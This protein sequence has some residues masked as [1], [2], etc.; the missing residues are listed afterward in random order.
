MSG[1]VRAELGPPSRSALPRDALIQNGIAAITVLL[2]ATPL[3]PILY[4]SFVDRALYDA[5]QRFTLQNYVHLL[6]SPT[7]HEAVANTLLFAVLGTI[8]AQALGLATAI[9]VGRTD[10]PGRRIFGETLVWPLYLS[11][12]V[13]AFGWTIMYG[14][15][16]YVTGLA[17]LL[18]GVQQ[19]WDLYTI[20]G[21]AVVAGVAS[22]PLTFLYCISSVTAQDP[23][24]EAAARSVGAS[25]VRALL[26][27]SLPLLRPALVFSTVQNFVVI[28]ETLSIPLLLGNPVG[29]R[30]FTTYLY[31]EGLD[32]A[33]PD[34]GL[35]GAAAVVL[36]LVVTL[37]IVLQNR[38]LRNAQ[39]FV[40]VGGKASRP[41]P[42]ELGAWRW[43]AFA[44]LLF[45]LVFGV[46]AVLAGLFLRTATS[47]LTP[48][49]PPWEMLTWDNVALI[50]SYDAYVRSI[51]N[52]LIIATV[53]GAIGTLLIAMIALVAHRSDYRFRRAMETIALYP[54]AVPGLLIGLGAFYALM[55]F[56]ALGWLR[57]TIAILVV[58]FI[59]RYI[60]TG[61]GAVAPILLQ[62]GRDLDRGARSVG[63]DWWTT[64]TRILMGLIKSAMLACFA[65]LFI[66]F[67]KEYTAAVFL[68]APGSEVMGTTMLTFWVQGDAG[69]VAALACLQVVITALFLVLARRV[70]GV[71]IYG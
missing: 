39:R 52:T 16:G 15:S 33:R 9:L 2:V 62:I 38:L 66:H 67:V 64:C 48:F 49:V 40:T 36:V 65:L 35:V 22:A 32:A 51:W 37:L 6:A 8:I 29:L 1:L 47:F 42:L 10:V 17:S 18:T 7:F 70:F 63:A 28:V 46:L 59:M 57:N 34:Y 14:P 43:P 25:P 54:R 23:A 71:R 26:S 68:F 53:G 3:L 60:P 41:R 31:Q 24:L 44:F 30:F 20:P 56:P 21:L 69:P 61:Y 5:G 27:V 4:Q 55:L 13:M 19:P 58:V 45:Y 11:H 50:F 12:L